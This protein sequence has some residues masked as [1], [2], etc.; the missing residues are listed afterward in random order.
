MNTLYTLLLCGS[1]ATVLL[2]GPVFSAQRAANYEQA[3]ALSPKDGYIAFAYAEG[4]D[5]F[6]KKLCLKLMNDP[7]ILQAAGN[8]VLIPMPVYESP[9]KEQKEGL[10][11]HMGKLGVKEAES[12]PAIFMFGPK[13]RHYA[14]L[15][16]PD[17]IH[18]KPNEL[19]AEMRKRIAALKEQNELLDKAKSAQGV[20]KAKLLGAATQIKGVSVPGDTIKQIKAA[21]PKDESGFVRRLEFKPW[22]YTENLLERKL[23]SKT[24]QE[25][26]GQPNKAAIQRRLEMQMILKELDDKLADSA[27]TN[28]QKQVFCANAIGTIHRKGDVTDSAKIKHYASI[29]EKLAPDT[30]LGKSA[31]IVTR[32][33]VAKLTLDEGWKPTTLPSGTDPVELHGE[34]PIREPGTYVVT[35]T[36]ESG[37]EAL[38]TKEVRL[39]DGKKLIASDAHPGSAGAPHNTKGNVYR[40]NVDQTVASPRVFIIFDMNGKTNSRGSITITRQ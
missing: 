23:D 37:A 4:W 7:A 12:Y 25:L 6:S 22:G 19:A 28:E 32:A 17:V 33:W 5:K 34:L 3:A 14:T 10:E 35:F 40:L 31:P 1:A 36:Y 27:Y 9:S 11:A 30:T 39:Y 13:G 21:D 2:P 16:G 24:L 15:C 38:K 18:A 8:T 26:E 20:E 29:M